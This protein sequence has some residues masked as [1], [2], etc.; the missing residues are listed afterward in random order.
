MQNVDQ[1]VI[2]QYSGSPHLDA[3]IDSFNDAIDPS[4]DITA[5]Y[6]YVWNIQTAQGYGLDVLGRIVGVSRVFNIPT[7]GTFNLSDD[8][9]RTLIYAK[10]L[11]NICDGSVRAINAILM[12]LF[13]NVGDCYVADHFD[14]TMQYQLAFT[15]TP[16]QS[17]IL[18]SDIMPRPAGVLVAAE[19]PTYAALAVTILAGSSQ[20]GGAPSYGFAANTA[21]AT[22]GSGSYSFAWSLASSIGGSWAFG[23]PGAQSTAIN[24]SGVAATVTAGATVTCTATDTVTGLTATSSVATYAYQNTQSASGGGGAPGSLMV[25]IQAGQSMGGA[26]RSHTFGANMATVTG[27]TAP[28]TYSWSVDNTNTDTTDGGG[29][30]SVSGANTISAVPSVNYVFTYEGEDPTGIG[31]P[32]D[33]NLYCTVTDSTP[34]TPLT[35]TSLPAHYHWLNTKYS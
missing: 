33:T 12:L 30:W 9:F 1:T 34:G 20:S 23:S 28:Y 5:F 13:P 19:P 10:A 3:I 17:A 24:V 27:G 11:S 22:G 15:P 16:L 35:A 26:S 14:M 6:N 25:T 7:F 31:S 29:V 4:A 32:S 18:A 21:T 8:A 2:A